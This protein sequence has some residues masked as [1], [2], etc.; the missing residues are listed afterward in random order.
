MS[1]LEHEPDDEYDPLVEE[2]DSYHDSFV[3]GSHLLAGFTLKSHLGRPSSLLKHQTDVFRE[4]YDNITR[5]ESLYTQSAQLF[6][7]TDL[8]EDFGRF[9]A[10]SSTVVQPE[11]HG[12]LYGGLEEEATILGRVEQ[13]RKLEG[14]RSL[15]TA[16][17]EKA[18]KLVDAAQARAEVL[19]E[20]AQALDAT[21]GAMTFDARARARRKLVAMKME[22]AKMQ[23]EADEAWKEAK[24]LAVTLQD[25]SAVSTSWL[26]ELGDGSGPQQRAVVGAF[27]S[28]NNPH[29]VKLWLLGVPFQVRLYRYRYRY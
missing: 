14:S 2:G 15:V 24:Q 23:E 19:R 22:S 1:S 26:D 20:K 10:P 28:N 11:D 9:T 25:P 8:H 29:G 4:Q 3:K 7:K 13:Y 5:E 18:R 17:N 6:G 27:E 21:G 12:G 16:A